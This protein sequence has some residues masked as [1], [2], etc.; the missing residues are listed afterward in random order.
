MYPSYVPHQLL[1]SAMLLSLHTSALCPT[2]LTTIPQSPR[3]F[4][5]PPS[6]SPE[7][8][9]PRLGPVRVIPFLHVPVNGNFAL[10]SSGYGTAPV[11]GCKDASELRSCIEIPCTLNPGQQKREMLILSKRMLMLRIFP[12]Y[13]YSAPL[14]FFFLI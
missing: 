8:S 3:L 2:D 13:L 10:I 1:L 12:G 6:Y 4:P 14:P 9:F 11:P 5:V 7:S